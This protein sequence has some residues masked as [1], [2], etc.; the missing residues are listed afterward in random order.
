MQSNPN[1][2]SKFTSYRLNEESMVVNMHTLYVMF[3]T[4]TT[5]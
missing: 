4:I 1:I 2:V 3:T 5:L